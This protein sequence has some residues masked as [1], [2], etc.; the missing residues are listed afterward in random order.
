MKVFFTA[1]AIADDLGAVI[2][3]ALFYTDDVVWIALL[4]AIVIFL[5]LMALN[6][7]RV[8]SLLPYTLLCIALWLAF[9]ESGIHPT[10][11]GVLLALTIPTRG[12]PD[13]KALLAQCVT[14]LNQVNKTGTVGTHYQGRIQDAAQTLETV[15]GRLQSPALR[16][17]HDLLPWTTYVIL[18][19]FALANAGVTLTLDKSLIGPVS[20]GI[21]LGLVVGKPVGVT[22]LTWLAVKL[23]LAVLPENV[24]WRQLGS[25]SF[26][27]GIGFTMSLFIAN[28]AFKDPEIIAQAKFGILVAS[29]LA[30]VIGYVLTLFTSPTYEET[31]P[32]ESAPTTS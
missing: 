10:I 20:L 23:R 3:I 15:S 26:L 9:L 19:I 2:V 22:L 7:A 11:A 31:T 8:Y 32:W 25:A 16:L 30:G 13:T 21:L 1:L 4:A 17:E 29:L 27:T 5:I 18:P 14:V 6:R 24:S 28:A 12:S